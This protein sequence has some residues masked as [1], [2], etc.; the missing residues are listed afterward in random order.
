[1]LDSPRTKA[2]HPGVMKAQRTYSVAEYDDLKMRLDAANNELWCFV[3]MCGGTVRIPSGLL[4]IAR[5][6]DLVSTY[7]EAPGRLL[8]SKPSPDQE[9]LEMRIATVLGPKKSKR[10]GK[11]RGLR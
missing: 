11:R 10:E 3:Q 4:E 7:D 9:L 2:E 8:M 5:G 6:E 1:A